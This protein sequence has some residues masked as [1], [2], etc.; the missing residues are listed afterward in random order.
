MRAVGQAELRRIGRWPAVW[1]LCGSWVVLN[2][3]FGYVFTYLSYRSDD[4]SGFAGGG[5]RT[6]LLAQVM[7]D[8]APITLVQGMA[9]FGG[10][11]LMLLGALVVGNGY[12]WGTWKTVFTVGPRR[13]TA[14]GGTLTAIAVVVAGLVAVTS[15]L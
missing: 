4:G 9:M 11:L 5:S 7:P 3:T 12:G 1:V 13:T 14:V 15:G 8:Q 2:L 10:A 6:V